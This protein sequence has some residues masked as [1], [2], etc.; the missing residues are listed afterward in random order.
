MAK[1]KVEELSLEQKIDNL[2]SAIG[3]LNGRIGGLECAI[4]NIRNMLGNP[5]SMQPRPIFGGI[6]QY[7]PYPQPPMGN[8]YSTYTSPSYGELRVKV[9]DHSEGSDDTNP[10]ILTSTIGTRITLDVSTSGPAVLPSD[11][12]IKILITNLLDKQTGKRRQCLIELLEFSNNNVFGNQSEEF[13]CLYSIVKKLDNHVNTIF[14][15]NT[16]KETITLTINRL[17]PPFGNTTKTPTLLQLDV[18]R[19]PN[20]NPV[21]TIS[22]SGYKR[23]PIIS[24]PEVVLKEGVTDEDI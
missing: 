13:K 8:V 21:E 5:L 19:P 9:V 6:H 14:Y 2:A 20:I 10:T 16:S 17:V 7:A 18:H 11:C 1:A 4:A 23:L 22:Y 3:S 12:K 15:P 24:V